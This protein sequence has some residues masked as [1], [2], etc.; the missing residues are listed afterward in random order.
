M[1]AEF[2][3]VQDHPNLVRDSDSGAILSLDQRALKAYRERK[4]ERAES[5]QIQSRL[6][7]LEEKLNY[8]LSKL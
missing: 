4:K 6:R 2:E 1:S 7:E 5:A 8:L 3:L